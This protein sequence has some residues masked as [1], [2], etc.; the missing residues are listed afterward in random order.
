MS[1]YN[2]EERR[3][4]VQNDEGLYDAQRMSG[5]NVREFVRQNRTFIDSV[6][7]TVMS[8]RKPAHYL[9]YD[10]G[11]SGFVDDV[12]EDMLKRVL[13]VIKQRNS[14]G[15]GIRTTETAEL[16]RLAVLGTARRPKAGHHDGSPEADAWFSVI[17]SRGLM[18][19]L[20]KAM[21]EEGLIEFI[22][23]W[24]YFWIVPVGYPRKSSEVVPW[25]NTDLDRWW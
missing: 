23:R 2:D 9:K 17:P 12:P 19:G 6:I 22:G 15:V 14:S 3:Q 13:Q 5:L 20:L 16:Y 25:R 24:G 8:G 21:E 18:S 4:W 7:E 11:L 1:K 10:R